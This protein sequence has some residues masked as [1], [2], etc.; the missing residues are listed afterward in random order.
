MA[1]IDISTRYADDPSRAPIWQALLERAELQNDCLV[2]AN[3]ALHYNIPVGN[4]I[5]GDFHWK[6][7]AYALAHDLNAIGFLEVPI[8]T[9]D[10]HRCVLPEHLQLPKL[11]TPIPMDLLDLYANTP[12]QTKWVKMLYKASSNAAGCLLWGGCKNSYGYG[13]TPWKGKTWT[14]HRLSY[15]FSKGLAPIPNTDEEGR[16][17][18]IRHLCDNKTCF[19]PNHLQIGTHAENSEDYAK[20][21]RRSKSATSTNEALVRIIVDDLKRMASSSGYISQIARKH[22]VSRTVVSRIANGKAHGDI[23]GVRDGANAINKKAREQRAIPLTQ[24]DIDLLADRVLKKCRMDGECMTYTGASQAGYGTIRFQSKLLFAHDIICRCKMRTDRPSGMVTRHLCHN[25]LCCNPAHL[26]W[27]SVTE[28]SVDTVRD[29]KNDLICKLRLEDAQVIK[30]LLL[31]GYQVEGIC[32]HFKV[33]QGC[34][35]NIK[36][37]LTWKH[38]DPAD[39]IPDDLKSLPIASKRLSSEELSEIQKLLSQGTP[40]KTIAKQFGMAQN[41]ISTVAKKLSKSSAS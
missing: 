26:E 41:T 37:G 19:H 31:D 9:C 16:K 40:Q 5:S 25:R 13:S 12:Y 6:K 14:V 33:S 36:R 11:H 4:A 21:G 3:K 28:N 35:Y 27:G 34:V 20:T 22:G 39:G 8:N 2:I 15:S 17:L 23:S 10:T 38:A 32:R 24:N 7:I 29:G 30:R 18:V 1:I